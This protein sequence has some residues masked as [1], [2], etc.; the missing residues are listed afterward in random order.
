MNDSRFAHLFEGNF[1]LDPI[2]IASIKHEIENRTVSIN[3]LRLELQKLES[4]REKYQTL[5][6]P[7]RCNAVPPEILGQIFKFSLLIAATSQEKRLK[8][9]CLVCRR[10][11]DVALGTPSLWAAVNLGV[12][13]KQGR[14]LNFERIGTWLARSGVVQKSLKI[15]GRHS[16]FGRCPLPAQELSH[17]LVDRAP[18]GT[19]SLECDNGECLERIFSQLPRDTTQNP[20]S[21]SMRS[22]SLRM[23]FHPF[24]SFAHVWSILHRFPALDSLSLD[25]PWFDTIWTVPEDL[26]LT[27]L[28]GLT[29]ACDW[30]FLSSVVTILRSCVNLETLVMDYK[31][32]IR[33]PGEA[34]PSISDQVLLPR[35]RKLEM[36]RLPSE[37]EDTRFL[38]FLRTP[39]LQTLKIRFGPDSLDP[40]GDS[41]LSG[42][43]SDVTS[44]AKGPNP[45]SGLQHL[46][47]Q[48]IPISSSFGL[49]EVIHAFPTLV[50]L[51]LDG[52]QSDSSMFKDPFYFDDMLL[53]NL[54]VLKVLNLQEDGDFEYEEMFNFLAERREYATEELPDSL[55]EVEVSI[56]RDPEGQNH[57]KD[58]PHASQLA[59]EGVAV[60]ISF[61]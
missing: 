1:D 52:L 5:L 6:S 21:T 47:I 16:D 23:V 39:S 22:L 9:L 14:R 33:E 55:E 46:F 15:T 30:P 38:C 51:T 57:P 3:G 24:E 60:S 34:L 59:E 58:A 50:H 35:L 12:V 18:F 4:E 44:L 56:I 61:V 13:R 28:T 40:L 2:E 7:L 43:S 26:R 45:V 27:N 17:L 11:R 53:P 10:W 54:K 25:L 49:R 42:F 48:A 36:Q 41:G 29:L 32:L 31:R 20:M 8:V 19:L 37:S